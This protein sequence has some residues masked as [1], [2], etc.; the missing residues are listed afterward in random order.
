MSTK[1]TI[2]SVHH[3]RLI[4]TDPIRSRDFYTSL[5]NFTVAAE[6]PP[7]FVLTDGNMLLGITPP[8]DASQAPPNDRFSPHRVG[9]DHLSFGVAN[10]AE[11]HK[12]AALFEEH[13]VEHGEVRDLPAFGITI[14]SFSDPD[15]IQ[16][17]LTAPLE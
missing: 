2:S 16:L 11:L 4:V 9:L 10:R 3:I 6:L 1:I 12:A 15:G 14:L 7:G 13:G 5:L 8:W 17:E